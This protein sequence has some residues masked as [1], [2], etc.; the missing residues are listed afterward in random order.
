MKFNITLN[1]LVLF[2]IIPFSGLYITKLYISPIY[3]FVSIGSF[4][5][6]IFIFLNYRIKIPNSYEFFIGLI[7]FVYFTLQ[8]LYLNPNLS[9]YIN[10]N[11]SLFL[12]LLTYVVLYRTKTISIISVSEKLVYFSIPLLIYEAYYRITNPIFF[13]DFAAKGRE[14]LFF[15]YFKVNSIMYQDSNFVGLF[16]L[17]LIF[18]LL[19]IKEITKKKY[20]ILIS[21]LVVLIFVTLS[22]SSIISFLL[23]ILFFRLRHIIYRY[24]IISFIAFSLIIS[25]LFL[26]FLNYRYIDDSF[27]TKFYILERTLEYINKTDITGILFGVGF[28]NAY[29]V[30]D[31]GAHNFFVCYLVESGL[32]GLVM[33]LILWTQILLKTR[34]KAGVVIFPFLLNGMSLTT[35]AIPY[36]Y[37]MFSVILILESRKNE[38]TKRISISNY[39][40]L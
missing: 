15:Y 30:L 27:S 31:I 38:F 36:L 2:F 7:L 20:Y 5:S 8:I 24:R 22:R 4:F 26:V 29:S 10:F 12:F 14:D 6:L 34:F 11:F 21:I 9:T 3:I 19:Y 39:S 37:C 18:F 17:S 25:M 35:G 16:I 32:I 33:V 40:S 23:G 13:V 28:G 1:Y